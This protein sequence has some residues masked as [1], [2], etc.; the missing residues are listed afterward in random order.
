[1]EKLEN[2]LKRYKAAGHRVQTALASMPDDKRLTPKHIRTGLDLSKSDMAGFARLLISK[3]IITEAEYIEA[4]TEAAEEEAH[5]YEI[6]I[7]ERLGV[8]VKTS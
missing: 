1:M 7:S 5:S 2:L 6:E 4:I 3:D 8:R